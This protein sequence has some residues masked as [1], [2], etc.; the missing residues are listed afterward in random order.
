MHGMCLWRENEQINRTYENDAKMVSRKGERQRSR[1]GGKNQSASVFFTMVSEGSPRRSS[2]SHGECGLLAKLRVPGYSLLGCLLL[3]P[4][5][6]WPQF[7]HFPPLFQK[8]K[9]IRA[10]YIP[11]GEKSG[12]YGM[13]LVGEEWV[14]V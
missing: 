10:H 13:G 1:D 7:E 11:K 8:R 3:S 6:F 4:G 9:Y 14:L 12:S 5:A 2:K